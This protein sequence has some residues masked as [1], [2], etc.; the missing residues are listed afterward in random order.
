V[1]LK[2]LNRESTDE[3]LRIEVENP[4][5]KVCAMHLRRG[6]VTDSRK[7]QPIVLQKM[8]APKN[9]FIKH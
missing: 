3:R 6:F 1:K 9:Y 8:T 5:L 2:K 4:Q 7:L